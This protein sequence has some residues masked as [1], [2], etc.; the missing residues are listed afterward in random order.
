MW[1]ETEK[2]YISQVCE[3]TNKEEG[4][5]AA[6]Y[7]NSLLVTLEEKRTWKIGIVLYI[8]VHINEAWDRMGM[9]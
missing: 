4:L 6:H 5:G 9:T 8:T 7:Q 2:Q 3:H 1:K